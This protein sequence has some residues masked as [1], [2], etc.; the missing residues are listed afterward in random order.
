MA[1][2]VTCPHCQSVIENNGSLS[3]QAVA[4]SICSGEFIMPPVTI[5]R[6]EPLSTTSDMN[7]TNSRP[8]SYS[9]FE[10]LLEH[11][12][13]QPKSSWLIVGGVAL[14]LIFALSRVE[15]D[16]GSKTSDLISKPDS[17]SIKNDSLSKSEESF[18]SRFQIVV[19][20][21]IDKMPGT[22]YTNQLTIYEQKQRY[23]IRQYFN[24]GTSV[25]TELERKVMYDNGI[26]F[27]SSDKRFGE[28]YTIDAKGN[29]ECWDRMGLI[30]IATKLP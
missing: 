25:E 4:C 1:E 9:S 13:S 21:W 12:K 27:I 7:L 17:A 5:S 3:G 15:L 29:L 23:F 2:H 14:F 11:L 18:P 16:K 20:S 8:N 10:S 6:V 22:Q 24:D 19:G 30:F 26:R 28:Y